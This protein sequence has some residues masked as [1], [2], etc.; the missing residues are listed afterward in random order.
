MQTDCSLFITVY[1]VNMVP[2]L[3]EIRIIFFS[4]SEEKKKKYKKKK[5]K[6]EGKGKNVP[7]WGE[8]VGWGNG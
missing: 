8:R 6:R 5:N 2:I 4:F 7:F 1:N 3:F